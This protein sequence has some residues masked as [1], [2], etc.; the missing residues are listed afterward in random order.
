MSFGRPNG[1]HGVGGYSVAVTSGGLL[2]APDTGA[3]HTTLVT[4]INEV[5]GAG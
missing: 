4:A 1:A 2:G 3:F 5:S